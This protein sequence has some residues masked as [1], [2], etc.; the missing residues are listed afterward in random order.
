M[1]NL[2]VPRS[3]DSFRQH[4]A[5]KHEDLL[6]YFD[7]GWEA[8][9]STLKSHWILGSIIAD[10][11]L[12]ADRL[13]DGDHRREAFHLIQKLAR[14]NLSETRSEATDQLFSGRPLQ[15]TWTSW[16]DFVVM[17]KFP[18]TGWD[19]AGAVEE[20][21]MKMP[22]HA[23]GI[24]GLPEPPQHH[25]MGRS[26]DVE[27]KRM[28]AEKLVKRYL[29]KVNLEAWQRLMARIEDEGDIPAVIQSIL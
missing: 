6:T 22:T 13:R 1:V 26:A 2:E 18:P 20:L 17:S 4:I 3:H 24:L 11:Q 28:L 5:S 14:V 29:D 12:P 7:S 16:T 27:Y 9:S 15:Y 10:P 8:L 19:F 21:T 23:G 25:G